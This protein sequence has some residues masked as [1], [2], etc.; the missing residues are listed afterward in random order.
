MKA[1]DMKAQWIILS[2]LADSQ[3][4]IIMSCD[5]ARQSLEA[6]KKVYGIPTTNRMVYLR[7]KRYAQRLSKCSGMAQYIDLHNAI[8]A[9]LLDLGTPTSQR[10][11]ILDWLHGLPDT[12][13]S[14]V[15]DYAQLENMD[16]HLLRQDLLFAESKFSHEDQSDN[17][18]QTFPRNSRL[19]PVQRT[20]SNSQRG[21]RPWNQTVRFADNQHQY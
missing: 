14:L 17:D 4:P 8:T 7:Q 20:R 1:A 13:M 15:R 21:N 9:Q 5:T 12:Y 6:L 19:A 18:E 10:D 2:H 3:I 11:Q 16:L